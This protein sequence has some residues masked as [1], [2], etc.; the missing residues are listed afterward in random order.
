[1]NIDGPTKLHVP[2]YDKPQTFGEI[3]TFDYP[4]LNS[5]KFILNEDAQKESS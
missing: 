1:M 4:V 2:G 3:M 5:G